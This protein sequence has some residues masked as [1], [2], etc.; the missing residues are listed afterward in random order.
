MHIKWDIWRIVPSMIFRRKKRQIERLLKTFGK[1]KNGSF[2]FDLI[3]NYYRKKDNSNAFQV[4]SDRTCNDLDFQELFMFVDRTHSKVGQQ[5]LYNKLRTITSDSQ[6]NDVYEPIITLLT[7]NP[8]IRTA[9]Q[10]K[11]KKLNNKEA[12]FISALIQEN[13]ITPPKW[14]FLVKML[15]ITSLFLVILFFFYSQILMPLLGV[16][17]INLV[18]HSLNKKKLHQY[19]GTIPQLLKLQSIAGELF[20]NNQLKKIN[21]KLPESIN[22]LNQIRNRMWFFKLEGKLEGDLQ[23]AFWAIFELIKILFLVEPLLLFNVLKELDA[24]RKE[25]EDVFTYVGQIDTLVSIASLRKGLRTCCIPEIHGDHK[26][27]VTAKNVYHPLI[28]NCIKN[29]INIDGKSILLTGSNMSGKTSFI[30]TIG[31]NTLT[32][33]TLNTCFADQYSLPRM[34][35]FSAIRISDDLLNDR[36]YYFEEVITIKEMVKESESGMPNLFL[37]DEIYS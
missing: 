25:I 12:N 20:K 8:D 26:I 24:K 21:P 36:S 13:H 9:I 1:V 18:I 11:L 4:I 27:R 10:M 5:Y 31:I 28:P 17:I 22:T 6:T 3:E 14:F 29:S 37:L 33:L 23:L 35:V 30:R 34:R 16:F 2:D 19:I 7:N 32:A 15:S